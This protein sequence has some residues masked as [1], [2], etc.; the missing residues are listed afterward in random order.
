MTKEEI[1]IVPYINEYKEHIK[2][3]NYEW[4]E[5]YFFIEPGDVEQLT[6]PQHYIIDK[7]GHIY[8]AKYRDQI[9]GTSSLMKTGINEY[10]LA[11]MAVTEKYKGQG[12]GQM[13]LEHCLAEAIKLNAIKLSL[14]SNT[15]LQ[16]AI[17][18]YKKFGFT[19]SALPTDVH[20]ERAD[21]MMEKYLY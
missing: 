10:E 14:F 16:S 2:A 12:I 17:H 4:L 15:K 11:K 3:L 8:F 1:T 18:L 20:Y 19:E 6:D 9:V 21:V 7:G 13:L 5:K